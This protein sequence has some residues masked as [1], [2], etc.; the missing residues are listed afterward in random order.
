MLR[1]Q[2]RRDVTS[3]AQFLIREAGAAT[4][5]TFVASL[6]RALSQIADNPEIGSPRWG[7]LLLVKGLR[8]WP[9][10]GFSYTIFYQDQRGGPTIARIL[11]SSRDIPAQLRDPG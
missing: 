2:A 3:I 10:K 5:G 7:Q 4:A 9:V 8:T 6:D 11:H 1:G